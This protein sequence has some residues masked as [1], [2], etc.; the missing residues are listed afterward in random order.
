MRVKSPSGLFVQFRVRQ[1]FS[2]IEFKL[3]RPKSAPWRLTWTM[4][5]GE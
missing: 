1:T 2:A 5:E 4:Q 3:A